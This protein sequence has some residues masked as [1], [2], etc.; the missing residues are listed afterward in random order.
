MGMNL[1][2]VEHSREY[3]ETFQG[4]SEFIKLTQ[5][6]NFHPQSKHSQLSPIYH[7]SPFV[8]TI[9]AL[10]FSLLSY[11]RFSSKI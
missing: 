4:R 6:L 9:L 8:L 10:L 1:S 5:L 7:F 3:G 11:T 2:L